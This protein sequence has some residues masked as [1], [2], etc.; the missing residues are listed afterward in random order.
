[1]ALKEHDM[2]VDE[3]LIV[4]SPNT[5]EAVRKATRIL[6][7]NQ[8]DVDAIMCFND[9]MAASVLRACIEMGVAVPAQVAVTG[10]DDIPFADLLKQSLTTMHVPRF[11]L[12]VK[13][14]EMLLERIDGNTSV[15]EI[16]ISPQLVVRESAP[17]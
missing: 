17:Y 10:F 9:M 6:L 11:D 12:G 2:P 14:G 3:K 1:M 8:P 13:A 16:V 7:E 4:H 15:S 5:T